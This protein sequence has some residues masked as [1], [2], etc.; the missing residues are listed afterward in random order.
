M[1]LKGG[2]IRGI[3]WVAL[4]LKI[5]GDTSNPLTYL[6]LVDEVLE[7]L[8]M[9]VSLN[10]GERGWDVSNTEDINSLSTEIGDMQLKD[11]R[12][13]YEQ[14]CEVAGKSAENYGR[15]RKNYRTAIYGAL[16]GLACCY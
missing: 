9:L 4:H 2:V 8:E 1:E 16:D 6:D 7:D 15:S 14:L 3:N 12:S 5:G 11:L 10:I 13:V